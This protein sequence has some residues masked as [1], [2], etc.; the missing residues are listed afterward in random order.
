MITRILWV[1]PLTRPTLFDLGYRGFN[2]LEAAIWFLCAVLVMRRW[3]RNHRS[4]FEPA[5]AGAFL[6]FGLTDVREAFQLDVPLLVVKSMV[7][8]ALGWLRWKVRPLYPG[9]KLL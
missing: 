4:R 9:S 8:L 7:L 3:W 6:L 5:Y 2:L 1:Y